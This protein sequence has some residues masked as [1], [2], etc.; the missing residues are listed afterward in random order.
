MIVQRNRSVNGILLLDKPSGLTSN[1]ALQKVKRLY[2]ARKAGHT[3]S[4]DPLASGMLPICLGEA[5]KFAG[6]LLDANKRYRFACQLGVVTDTGDAEGE[7]VSTCAVPSLTQATVNDALAQL[8][9][10]IKQL[11]PMYSALKH[12]GQRLYKLARQGQVVE[13]QPRPVTIHSLHLLGLEGDWIECE[14]HCS[15]GTYVR[16]LATD[17][18]ELLGCGAHVVALRRVGVEPYVSQR[19]ESL[20]E[21]EKQADQGYGALD[22]LLLPLD[23]AL[24]A[25]PVFRVSET[26]VNSL[27]QGHSVRLDCLA[28]Q[29]RVR[30]YHAER[31]LGVGEIR[32][33]ERVIPRRLISGVRS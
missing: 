27:F 18:G 16:T 29:G 15:K 30:L 26:M 31:F 22:A 21:L 28:Q 33:G 1:A 11:P 7:V 19:M 5:T 32:D 3:G 17:L 12:Q 6:F 24:A 10:D 20:D 23:S 8:T 14:V 2:C 25:W 9:G 13:R 4:L